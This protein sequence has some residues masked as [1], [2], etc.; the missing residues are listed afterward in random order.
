MTARKAAPE[1]IRRAGG[2]EVS[3]EEW[4]IDI[5]LVGEMKDFKLKSATRD[6][7]VKVVEDIFAKGYV[8]HDQS[9][10]PN[11]YERH[12]YPSDQIRKISIYK[13]R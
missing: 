10:L 1:D 2:T 12:V 6:A 3:E 7:A 13:F 11:N 8:V 5:D 4:H 9:S